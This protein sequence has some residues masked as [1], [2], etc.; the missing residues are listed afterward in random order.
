MS[1]DSDKANHPRAPGA[2]IQTGRT[3]ATIVGTG[4]AGATIFRDYAAELQPYLHNSLQR[5]QYAD[6]AN[7]QEIAGK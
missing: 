3:S 1:A 5:L 2:T 7:V 6:R 4:G